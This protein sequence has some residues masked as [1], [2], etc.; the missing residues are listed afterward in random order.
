[1]WT[2]SRRI[3]HSLLD[4]IPLQLCVRKSCRIEGLLRRRVLS[5]C[6]QIN[7]RWINRFTAEESST[8]GSARIRFLLVA[9]QSRRSATWC[10]ISVGVRWQHIGWDIVLLFCGW[11]NSLIG[12]TSPVIA[13]IGRAV[14]D[15]DIFLVEPQ[16]CGIWLR[17]KFN[18][19]LS[20]SC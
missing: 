1:M 4:G 9:T 12:I 18:M 19:F 13:L 8:S 17:G 10:V 6:S 3:D 14:V 20:S 16:P 15:P 5:S 11:S 7:A 2:N